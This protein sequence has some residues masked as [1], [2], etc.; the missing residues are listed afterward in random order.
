V[1]DRLVVLCQV[2]QAC[3]LACGFCGYDRRL[4]G[5]RRSADPARLEA[6]GRGLAELQSRTGRPVLVSWLGGEPLTWPPLAALSRLFR[7]QLGLAV[8]VTT[9][10]TTL[11]SPL[12]RRRLL[13]DHA[14]VTISIDGLGDAHDR[15]RGWP[16]GFAFLE[17]TIARLVAERRGPAPLLRANTVVMHDNVGQLPE[18]WRRLAGWGLDE[19]TW[20]QLGGRDRPEFFP[21]HRL[22]PTDV[23]RLGALLP[24]L[25]AELAARGVRLSGNEAYLG[26]AAASADDRPLPVADCGPGQRF[27]FVS[28]DGQVSPCSFTSAELGVAAAALQPDGWSG[29]PTRFGAARARSRPRSCADCPSTQVFGKFSVCR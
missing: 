13:E 27:L 20:N 1:A 23:Q 19:L 4:P 25:R 5:A 10:G 15:L 18:L 21:A 24:G 3:Q 26:R 12:A 9:N 2:T 14:E 7:H 8:S 17:R 16:G 6:L 11:G 29:L 22:T 28:V